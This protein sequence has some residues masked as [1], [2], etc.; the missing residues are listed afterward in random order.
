MIASIVPAKVFL[1]NSLNYFRRVDYQYDER[2]GVVQHNLPVSEFLF[3]LALLNSFVFDYY[4]R[5]RI[6]ANLNT[7]FL[8]ELP[9]PECHENEKKDVVY[10]VLKLFRDGSKP[11]MELEQLLEFN[12]ASR[13]IPG[14]G[15]A[16]IV[17]CLGSVVKGILYAVTE[18]ELG[19]LDRYEGVPLHYRRHRVNI[20]QRDIGQVVSAVTYV[21]NP[22]RVR[23]GMKPTREYLNHLLAGADCLSEEHVRRLWAVETLD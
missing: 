20:E 21:A 18:E 7:F 1:G 9:I 4:I 15:F 6:S 23:N 19:K 16:N 22:E 2:S 8:Y 13:N 14:T 11:F 3:L 17:P 10:S 12:K 5:L